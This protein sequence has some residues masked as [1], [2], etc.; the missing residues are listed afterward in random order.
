MA[1]LKS[2]RKHLV[3]LLTKGEAH[4]T[5]E[6]AVKDVPAEARGTVPKG[7]A[8]SLWELMEHMRIAQSDILK[9]STDAKHKSPKWPKGYWPKTPA[10]P[11]AKAWD[12]TIKDFLADRDEM[13]KLIEKKSTD[14]FA[15]I[16]HGEGQTI[17]REVLLVADHNAYH[18]GEV[19]IT[20]RLLGVWKSK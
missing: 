1:H 15:E 12:K 7:A 19:V 17:L 11:N 2:L 20:R 4:A 10:P 5:F 9:F 6:D 13:C 14:L 16:K 8:H 3:N 18:V